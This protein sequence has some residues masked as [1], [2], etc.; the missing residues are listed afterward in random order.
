M[1][2]ERVK[3]GDVST[4]ESGFIRNISQFV[5]VALSQDFGID[6]CTI[7]MN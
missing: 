4:V 1:C 5:S 2:R 6:S 7:K 3:V